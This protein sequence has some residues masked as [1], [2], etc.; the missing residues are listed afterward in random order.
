MM[1]PTSFARVCSRFW[2]W[3]ISPS[4]LFASVM[5]SFPAFLFQKKLVVLV[6]EVS[7]FFLLALSRRGKLRL[8]PSIL[9]IAGI[10]FFALFSP[11]GQVYARWGAFTITA[12]ALEAGLTRGF[13]LA[14][15]VFLSQL[16]LS[17]QLHLPG[18]MGGFVVAMFSLLDKLTKERL[19]FSK[20]KKLVGLTELMTT[21]DTHL[22]QVYWNEGQEGEAKD[23]AHGTKSKKEER[24]F[25]MQGIV[26]ASLFSGILYVLLFV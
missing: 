20:K 25:T 18:K 19:V 17:P 2:S 4:L 3:L 5:V 1:L 26:A 13:T 21:L 24:Q 16:A 15:M 8:L 10:T 22:Y 11:H 12:G 9:M 6:A 23:K 7:V 14:G